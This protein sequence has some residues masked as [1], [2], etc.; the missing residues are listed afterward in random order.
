MFY[1]TA[2][3]NRASTASIETRSAPRLSRSY[4]RRFTFYVALPDRS[5]VAVALRATRTLPT[6][7]RLQR[8]AGKKRVSHTRLYQPEPRPVEP[9]LTKKEETLNPCSAKPLRREEERPTS[10]V[11]RSTPIRKFQLPLRRHGTHHQHDEARGH[12]DRHFR[13]DG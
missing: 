8:F 4:P 7:K 3:V 1:G 9:P 11:Q 13:F 12:C 6:G 2:S 5:I 10:N